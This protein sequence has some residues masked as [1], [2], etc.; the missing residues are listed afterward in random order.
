ML[1][2]V[3]STAAPRDGIAIALGAGGARGLA[4]IVV[5]EALDELGVRPV[6]ISGSSMGAIIGAAYAA[7]IPAKDIRSHIQRMF[8][9]RRRTYSGL[10]KARVGRFADLFRGRSA[11]PVL[12]DAEMLLGAFWPPD[13][14]AWFEDLQIPF[15][16]VA[17]DYRNRRSVAFES[18]LLTPAVAGSIALP[19]LVRPVLVDGMVL[20]DGGLT[21]PLP[22][23]ALSRRAGIVIASDVT[24][25]I[26]ARHRR[27]PRPYQ[28]MIGGAQIVQ[29]A[30]TQEMLKSDRPDVVIQ[31]EVGH[32]RALDFFKANDILAA[33]N[34]ARDDVKKALAVYLESDH[35]SSALTI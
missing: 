28:A 19:G 31:P 22:Y 21:D 34:S 14:P 17:T 20:V 5:L 16:A 33:A 13:V 25:S 4:H 12:I 9:S 27:P 1:K 29:F 10:L 15:S 6:A 11:N 18:G 32:F 8:G 2:K 7:G 35:V 24:G 3:L 30:L 23:R 26:A